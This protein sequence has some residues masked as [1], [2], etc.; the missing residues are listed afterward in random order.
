MSAPK[1]DHPRIRGEHKVWIKQFRVCGGSSPHTRGARDEAG[2][3]PVGPWIIPAYAGSTRRRTAPSWKPRDHPRI[4][5]E[6]LANA[7]SITNPYG[8]SPHTRGAHRPLGRPCPGTRIIPAYAGSTQAGA[9]LRIVATDHPRIR[10]EHP[11][12]LYPTMSSTRII[13]AYAGSTRARC[14]ALHATRDHPRIRGEHLDIVQVAPDTI[15]S[16]PHTRGAPSRAWLRRRPGGIIPAYAG[17]TLALAVWCAL[18]EDHPR[19][20]GEHLPSAGMPQIVPGSSPH[21]RGARA[22]PL[23]RQRLPGII[24]AY[25]GSTVSHPFR[26]LSVSDHPRIRGEHESR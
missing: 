2:E 7:A 9:S 3:G 15:E 4:R 24:P 16:S 8:S 20:R 23:P 21:T 14:T 6:H 1:A 26:V 13:P 17:S 10:G 18:D 22:A 5:G 11:R 19:I 12:I 25:A